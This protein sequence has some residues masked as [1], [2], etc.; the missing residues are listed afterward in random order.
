MIYCSKYDADI[1]KDL[2]I[3]CSHIKLPMS[4]G[5]TP[6]NERPR[7][8]DDITQQIAKSLVMAHHDYNFLCPTIRGIEVNNHSAKEPYELR[9]NLHLDVWADDLHINLL[10]VNQLK[11]TCPFI[12]SINKYISRITEGHFFDM[13]FFIKYIAKPGEET[14]ILSLNPQFVKDIVNLSLYQNW[15]LQANMNTIKF[16]PRTTPRAFAN[17]MIELLHYLSSER[18]KQIEKDCNARCKKLKS[19]RI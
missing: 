15:Q 2:D 16:T 5:V 1:K 6:Q 12:G 14:K 18:V 8:G 17:K 4:L 19:A 3:L 9:L 11:V 7:I 13:V 10:P